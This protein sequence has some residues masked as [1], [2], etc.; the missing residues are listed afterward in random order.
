[1]GKSYWQDIQ[2]SKFIGLTQQWN[3][4]GVIFISDL[5]HNYGLF[6]Y[7]RSNIVEDD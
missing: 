4:L 5:D 1:M 3:Y 2:W 6:E 7:D